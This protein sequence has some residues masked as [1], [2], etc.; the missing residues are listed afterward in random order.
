M[1]LQTY[2]LDVQ[3]GSQTEYVRQTNV[4]T[5]TRRQADKCSDRHTQ[6]ADKCTDRDTRQADPQA[7]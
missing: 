2:Q 6:Q 7:S 1:S 3:T 5:G 4:Q